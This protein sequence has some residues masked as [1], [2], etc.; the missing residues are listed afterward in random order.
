MDVLTE[1]ALTLVRDE[2]TDCLVQLVEHLGSERNKHAKKL[3]RVIQATSSHFQRDFKRSLKRLQKLL[4]HATSNT[5]AGS[6]AVSSVMATAIKLSSELNSPTKLNR[7]NLH[8]YRLHVK[9]LRDVL[10]LSDKADDEEF[11]EELGEVKDAIGDWHDWEEL[12]AIAGQLLDHGAS[13]KLIRRLNVS[14]NSKFERALT[15]TNHFRA[16]YLKSIR[17][18]DRSRH[19]RLAALSSPV[20]K[21]T[22]SIAAA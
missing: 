21:A 8:P 2:E 13:C 20:I 16:K 11:V 12:N 4:E 9:E 17:T 7:N 1:D 19:T 14:R 5:S 22:S 10:Q 3:H 15:V 18:K 6:D